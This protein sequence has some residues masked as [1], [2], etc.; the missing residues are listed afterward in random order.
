M[1]KNILFKIG[2]VG[3]LTSLGYLFILPMFSVDADQTCCP[4][5]CS[6]NDT[7]CICTDPPL[8]Y[9]DYLEDPCGGDAEEECETHSCTLPA[10]PDQ[11]TSQ[12]TGFPITNL[13]SCDKGC[14]ETRYGNCYE[15]PPVTPPVTPPTPSCVDGDCTD[16][17]IEFLP[18]SNKINNLNCE[19]IVASGTQVNNPVPV[20]ATYSHAINGDDLEA[21]YFY[22][23]LDGTTPPDIK[24]VDETLG[25]SGKAISNS[26]FGF[27]IKKVN[28]NWNQV[29]VPYISTKNSWKNIGKL[30]KDF[31]I[32]GPTGLSMVVIRD[33]NITQNGKDVVANF[34]IEFLYEESG[35]SNYQKIAE[36]KYDVF[37][38]ANDEFGFTPYDNY[39]NEKIQN[40]LPYKANEIRFFDH[41]KNTEEW[42]VDLV[43][44]SVENLKEVVTD[45]TEIRVDWI[46]ADAESSVKYVVGNAFRSRDGIVIKEP[47]EYPSGSGNKYDLAFEGEGDP[48]GL[49]GGSNSIWEIANTSVRSEYIDIGS[50]RGGSIDFEL[51]AFDI[52][53][54]YVSSSS[55]FNL[56]EWI[57]SKGGLVFSRGGTNIDVRLLNSGI[58]SSNQWFEK[59]GLKEEAVDLSTELLSGNIKSTSLLKELKHENS[60]KSYRAVDY[61]GIYRSDIYSHYIEKYNKIDP[62]IITEIVS[63]GNLSGKL[64]NYCPEGIN[65]NQKIY[66]EKRDGNMKVESNFSC[67]GKAVFLINGDLE[68]NPDITNANDYSACIF[69]VNG[70]TYIKEGIDQSTTK[71]GFDTIEA[72]IVSRGII[73]IEKENKNINDIKDGVFVYGGL[74]AFGKEEGSQ[75]SIILKRELSLLDRHIY[76]VLNVIHQPKYGKLIK[77]LFGGEKFVFKT[78][79][80][81]KPL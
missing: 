81:L 72:Y 17:K 66:V 61:N 67:D 50:N 57:E 12:N 27:M 26:S 44:P 7:D 76:P 65:C 18:S 70:D 74:V 48:T 16:V 43:K 33:L 13:V 2:F 79:L 55:T 14:D 77:Q 15:I 29:Y 49:I 68:I 34:K 56:G 35:I 19:S 42:I 25:T 30:T 37:G 51:T 21:I 73:E 59:Y 78:E 64:S 5:C 75:A 60:N 80:G 36:K 23:T 58:W 11:T 63:N 10:C 31:T 6:C 47:I 28:G 53:C 62:N 54:N 8:P 71:I 69:V 4:E 45:F 1:K 40:K 41:W 3:L 22:M 39:T 38:M 24:W 20:K 9:C 32:D 46:T 52:G